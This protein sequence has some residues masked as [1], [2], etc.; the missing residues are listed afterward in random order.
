MEILKIF[1]FKGHQKISHFRNN[2]FQMH[3]QNSQK[4]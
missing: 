3:L 4:E 2:L 1:K